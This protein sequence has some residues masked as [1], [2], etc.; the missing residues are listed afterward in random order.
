ME[1]RVDLWREGQRIF[2]LCPIDA[3]VFGFCNFFSKNLFGLEPVSIHS[4]A[5]LLLK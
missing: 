2:N 5:I 1:D 4:V 3:Y